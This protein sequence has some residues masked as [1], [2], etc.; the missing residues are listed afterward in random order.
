[1]T[2]A[3]HQAIKATLHFQEEDEDSCSG[4]P[5]QQYKIGILM[6]IVQHC[7]MQVYYPAQN[8]ALTESLFR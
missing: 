4:D 2:H 6:E 5:V 7:C 1:M 3:L 8:L